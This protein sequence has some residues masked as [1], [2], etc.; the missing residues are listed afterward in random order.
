M[1]SL[2]VLMIAYDPLRSFLEGDYV[3]ALLSIYTSTIGVVFFGLIIIAIAG[4]V[5]LRSGNVAAP[6]VAI[7]VM[8]VAFLSWGVLPAGIE[9]WV[10]L[11]IAISTA[12]AMWMVF[13]R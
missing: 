9:M 7:T 5:Y 1:S 12:A 6:M 13:R 2:P 4:A 8:A 11:I 3:G 10:Y